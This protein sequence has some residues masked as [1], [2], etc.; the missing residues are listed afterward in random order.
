MFK[1]N[2]LSTT[3]YWE[4][5]KRFGGSCPWM[6]HRVCGPGQSR[7]QKVFHWGPS[8]LCSFMFVQG[9]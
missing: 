3:K 2:F 8:C 4:A 9:G 1:T 6:P 5:Q 7:P